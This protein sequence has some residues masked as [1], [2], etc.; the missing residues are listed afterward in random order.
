MCDAKSVASNDTSTSML[1]SDPSLNA[2][3]ELNCVSAKPA[4]S[5]VDFAVIGEIN[6]PLELVAETL[7]IHTP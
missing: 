7:A 6:S 3:L 1:P 2:K 4:I 5:S